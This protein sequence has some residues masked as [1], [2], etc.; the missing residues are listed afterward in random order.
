MVKMDN[1]DITYSYLEKRIL[2]FIDKVGSGVYQIMRFCFLIMKRI[3]RLFKKTYRKSLF[4]CKTF[5]HYCCL[6]MIPS[7][8]NTIHF[9]NELSSASV[10]IFHMYN[11]K[12]EKNTLE[13]LEIMSSN[14]VDIILL[15]PSNLGN[16]D[17]KI[18]KQYVKIYVEI[19]NIGRDFAG[20]KLGHDLFEK[21]NGKDSIKKL[22]FCNDS[23]FIEPKRFNSF[24]QKIINSNEDFIAPTVTDTNI[25]ACSWFLCFSFNIFNQK[26]FSDFWKQYKPLNYRDWA[27]QKGEIAL[28]KVC[29]KNNFIP[30]ALYPTDKFVKEVDSVDEI[31][32]QLIAKKYFYY[33]LITLKNEYA[34]LNSKKELFDNILLNRIYSFHWHPCN[35]LLF[36]KTDFPF[37]KKDLYRQRLYDVS[38]ISYFFSLDE[39]KKLE[40]NDFYQ[41]L[42]SKG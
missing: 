3:Y 42:L 39:I 13:Y 38:Q 28:S 22:I 31:S 18:L 17:I 29:I 25:H 6:L 21:S 5:F 11:N 14:G 34:L 24:I 32:A 26:F 15:N 37:I 7:K 2:K 30:F 41:Q 36:L 23:V 19:N 33:N 16:Q 20:F 35:L 40:I 10:C 12:I 8:I 4:F 9:S 27:I 1:K